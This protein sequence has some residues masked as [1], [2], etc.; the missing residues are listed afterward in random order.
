MR[1]DNK[2]LAHMYSSGLDLS[3]TYVEWELVRQR[4]VL[5]QGNAGHPAHALTRKPVAIVSRPKLAEHAPFRAEIR[6]PGATLHKESCM[7][8]REHRRPPR[9]L[10]QLVELVWRS[11]TTLNTE[12]PGLLVCEG[13]ML[14]ELRIRFNPEITTMLGF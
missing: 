2:A 13:P 3:S 6:A 9:K 11:E 1:T 10:T 4:A 14:L 8:F 5:L 7:R 12:L